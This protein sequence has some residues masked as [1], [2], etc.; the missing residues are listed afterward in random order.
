MV[1][2]S[3]FLEIPEDEWL[4]SN[5][6]AFAVRDRFPVSPGH[7]LI[8]TRRVITTWWEATDAERAAILSLVDEVRQLLDGQDPRP[9]GYNVGFNAG[10]AAGQTVPHLHVHV[11]PR[12]LGD[13]PDPRGGVR[14]VIPWRGNYL[15]AGSVGDALR[16]GPA[17]P[18]AP[19]LLDAMANPRFDRIDLAV[20]F[21]MWSGLELLDAELLE[22]LARPGLKLRLLTTDYLGITEKAALDE[23]LRLMHG[24]LEALEVRVFQARDVSFHPKAYLFRSS[25]DEG[26]GLGFVGSANLSKGGLLRG[27]EWTLATKAPSELAEM[28]HRFDE[29]WD[30]TRSL[31]LTPEVVDAYVEVPRGLGGSDSS[32]LV[33]NMA[34]IEAPTPVGPTDIQAEAMAALEDTR[35]L[36]YGAGLVVMATGLGKTWL[37]ALDSSRPWA[38]RVLFLAHR[39]ELLTQAMSVFQRV[40]PM[41]TMR[42][43]RGDVDV[44]G[45]DL[46]FANVSTM[47]NRL[48]AFDADYFD[49][50]VVDEFHHASAPTYRRILGHFEPIFLLGLTATPDR[51]DGADLL[52]LCEDN[53]VYEA[54]LRVGIERGDLVPFHYVGVP[55]T[56]DFAPIP[57]RNGKFDPSALETAATT[58][59]R[60]DQALHEWT[61]HGGDR[62]IA[63]CVSVRHA[64]FMARHFAERGISAVAVHASEGSAPRHESLDA[65]ARGDVQVVFAVDLFN[66][67]IDVPMVDTVL[68]LRPTSSPVLFLQQL[69][70]GLRKAEGKEYLSVIDFVGNHRSFL[71]KPRILAGLMGLRVSDA[72]LR[73][74]VKSGE[75]ELPPGCS[76]AYEL[77][78]LDILATLLAARGAGSALVRFLE[79][80][81]D[82]AY[83]RPT[84]VQAF[85]AGLNVNTANKDGGWFALLDRA[86]LLTREE[87]DVLRDHG[88]LLRQIAVEPM[89]KSYKMVVLRAMAMGFSLGTGM[90]LDRLASLSRKLIARDPRLLADTTSASMPDPAGADPARW[91]AYWRKW[92]IAALL[93]E[94]KGQP[95]DLFTLTDGRFGLKKPV[96][97]DAAVTLNQMVGELVDWR[98]AWYLEV[99]APSP[100]ERMLLKVVTNGRTPIL[101]LD[102]NRN[103]SLPQGRDVPVVADG[104]RLKA[105]FVK[106]AVNVV[107]EDPQGP[108]VLPDL[109]WRWFGP[110]AGESGSMHR[111]EVTLGDTG[112]WELKPF[113]PRVDDSS[114]AVAA[115]SP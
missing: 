108:N 55:D 93:G 70:R 13:M 37:A 25:S 96:T 15:A 59:E 67:G 47:V 41:R 72:D 60:A 2:A 28:R 79:E 90:P 35:S 76:V 4:T 33:A 11:I 81:A 66:E 51:S 74:V 22:A 46:V 98:L 19:A 34:A 114:A 49:Y 105:D 107:R 53:L 5:E 8:V 27:V 30:D 39:D 94:L 63:F 16:A 73:A 21:V 69:G 23:L 86:G 58:L 42:W 87:Q 102:R 62:T 83:E 113:V 14:H 50:V 54:S 44:T 110:D 75:F 64:E 91:A 101:F 48:D 45:A 6:L 57:W 61:S 78:A 3:P 115:F 109:L 7:V 104:R 80:Q 29:M 89:T 52:A 12:Y 9:D 82:E 106:I 43:L 18:L 111:V 56:I 77:E 84:A 88:D 68:M 38:S 40:Q 71:M 1:P 36:G 26:V 17:R 99:K 112:E 10:D 103:A 92:P 100:A 24:Y 95:S 20:S 65:L 85:R 32:E 97:P 31:P